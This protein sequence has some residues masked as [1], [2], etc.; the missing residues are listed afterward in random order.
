[1]TGKNLMHKALQA[2]A[3]AVKAKMGQI[4][5]G[6]QE[7]QMRGPFENFMAGVADALGWK[8][9]CTGE[10]SL[11]NRL[12]RPDYAVHLNQLLAGY[13]ELKAP[14]VGAD[15]KRFKGRDREQ[16]QRFSAIPNIP[17]TDGNE[18]ALYRDGKPVDRIVRLSGDVAAD[19]AKAATRPLRTATESCAVR[20]MQLAQG[21]FPPIE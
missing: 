15:A 9:V 20:E 19:G 16:F 7:D 11:P 10:T 5:S 4:T 18:W 3:D 14:G 17:Y 13:V 1:M 6:E 8:V 2:F 21:L 12:G